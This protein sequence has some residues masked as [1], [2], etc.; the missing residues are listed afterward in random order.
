MLHGMSGASVDAGS[1]D[2]DPEVEDALVRLLAET[3]PV[4]E[5]AEHGFPELGGDLARQPVHAGAH[6]DAQLPG[7]DRTELGERALGLAR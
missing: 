6:V 1:F 3:A 4:E 5:H 2:D 7:D